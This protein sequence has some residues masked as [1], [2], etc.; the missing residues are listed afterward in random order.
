[1]AHLAR[2]C[3]GPIE[4]GGCGGVAVGQPV[5]ATLRRVRDAGGGS[6]DAVAAIVDVILAIGVEVGANWD[7]V[8]GRAPTTGIHHQ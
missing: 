5:R 7:A 8:S 4:G 3:L 2:R 1:L 6:V